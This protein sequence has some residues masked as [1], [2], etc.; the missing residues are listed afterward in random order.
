MGLK[1]Y[2]LS[3]FEYVDFNSKIDFTFLLWLTTFE[4]LELKPSYI[5]NLKVLM[6]GIDHEVLSGR[7]A[8]LYCVTLI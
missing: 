6:C 4:L 5:L 3:K 1:S 7:A 2:Q 8:F